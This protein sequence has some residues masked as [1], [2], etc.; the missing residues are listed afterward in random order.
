[1][2]V[3]RWPPPLPPC[4]SVTRG[5]WRGWMRRSVAAAAACAGPRPVRVLVTAIHC[6]GT[7][8]CH[9]R[10]SSNML[11]PREKKAE[12]RLVYVCRKCGLEEDAA[13]PYTYRHEIVKSEM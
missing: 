8:V 10:C 12:E 6:A 3:P 5:E 13:T 2:L 9:A 7:A 4:N 11:V 1:M